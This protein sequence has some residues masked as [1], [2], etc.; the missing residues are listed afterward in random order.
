MLD[1]N[2]VLLLHQWVSLTILWQSDMEQEKFY[3]QCCGFKIFSESGLLTRK[4]KATSGAIWKYRGECFKI[5][6]WLWGRVERKVNQWWLVVILKTLNKPVTH[7][8]CHSIP[9]T[10]HSFKHT[11]NCINAP[12]PLFP[13][14]NQ[15]RPL[16]LIFNF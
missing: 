13:E 15:V 10:P 8:T 16:P 9:Y 4:I 2:K 5:L 7:H 1:L 14:E 3:S 11:K 12:I 6:I